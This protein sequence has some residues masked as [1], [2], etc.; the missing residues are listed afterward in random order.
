MNTGV[1]LIGNWGL[2]HCPSSGRPAGIVLRS[3]GITEDPLIPL[4]FVIDL[5]DF[6]KPSS[7]PQ[8]TLQFPTRWSAYS[9]FDSTDV[10][11]DWW[12]L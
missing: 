8:S 1:Y 2:E 6:W 9:M 7:V 5:R 10:I 11:G 3:N 4:D 12:V